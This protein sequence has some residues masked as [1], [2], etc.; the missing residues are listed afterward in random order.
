MEI[1]RRADDG[2][3]VGVALGPEQPGQLELLGAVGLVLD[4]LAT[5][6]EDDVALEIELRLVELGAE[7]AGR[8]RR[9]R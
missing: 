8:R 7:I 2:V 4:A 1:G 6:V 9:S 5:L 3:V